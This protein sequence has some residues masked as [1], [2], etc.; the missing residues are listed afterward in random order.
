[1]IDQRR[2]ETLVAKLGPRDRRAAVIIVKRVS[3]VAQQEGQAAALRLVEEIIGIVR[4]E[5]HD[6]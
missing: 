5:D 3:E 1:M 2:V 4:R 6:H